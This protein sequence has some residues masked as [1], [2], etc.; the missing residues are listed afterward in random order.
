MSAQDKELLESPSSTMHTLQEI[1]DATSSVSQRD[2]WV[3]QYQVNSGWNEVLTVEARRCYVLLKVA[4]DHKL[5]T[6]KVDDILNGRVMG[7]HIPEQYS[8]GG[9]WIDIPDR[10]VVVEEGHTLK[11]TNNDTPQSQMIIQVVG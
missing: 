8:T 2:G 3:M 7:E 10:C 1:Y 6:V 4:F 9:V 5:M 11:L